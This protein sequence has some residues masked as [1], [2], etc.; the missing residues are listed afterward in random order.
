[1]AS[2]QASLSLDTVIPHLL[3]RVQTIQNEVTAHLQGSRKEVVSDLA[4]ISQQLAEFKTRTELL[5]SRNSQPAPSQSL[6]NNSLPAIPTLPAHPAI[7]MEDS[8]PPIDQ[9]I[10][11]PS[12]MT[13]Q[14]NP[15]MS[16]PPSI[17]VFPSPS[18]GVPSFIPAP[19][20]LSGSVENGSPIFIQSSQTPQYTTSFSEP[21]PATT[22]IPFTISLQGSS[23]SISATYTF[24]QPNTNGGTLNFTSGSPY[25]TNPPTANPSV[26]N[27]NG[28]VATSGPGNL[29]SGQA[30]SVLPNFNM[31]NS[32]PYQYPNYS[33]AASP[34]VSDAKTPVAANLPY[35]TAA[36]QT[37]PADP[38]DKLVS[39]LLQA[40][41]QNS[42][43]LSQPYYYCMARWH[44]TVLGLWQ[45]WSQGINGHPPL[46]DLELAWGPRWCVTAAERVYFLKHLP[47]IYYIVE[48]A[49]KEPGVLPSEADQLESAKRLESWRIFHGGKSLEWVAENFAQFPPYIHHASSVA[50]D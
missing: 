27:Y 12:P 46:R 28:D 24:K 22:S 47:I 3:Q 40:N 49:R 11:S 29:N 19:G 32:I 13:A 30:Q 38:I 15:S 18:A 20:H 26:A 5:V 17:F 8:P 25:S 23:S 21:I 44:T 37:T 50:V 33:P 48:S 36:S 35:S 31:N 7:P 1:M 10:P 14:S 41:S 34:S 16:L 9:V 45:E 6:A 4:S 39:N 2:V 43:Q 42:P